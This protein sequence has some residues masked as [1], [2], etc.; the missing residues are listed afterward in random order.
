[1]WALL[2]SRRNQFGQILFAMK[3]CSLFRKSKLETEMS[4]EMWRHIEPQTDLNLKSRMHLEEAGQAVLRKFGNVAHIQEQ[5]REQRGWT[6]LENLG[7]DFRFSFRSLRRSI[8]FSVAVI[9]TLAL[10]IGANTTIMSVVALR[11]E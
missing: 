6:W 8:G 10:Y 7:R 3:L 9:I 5:C 1:V 11:A 4:D 2:F